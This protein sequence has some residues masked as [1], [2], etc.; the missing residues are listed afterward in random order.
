MAQKQFLIDGGFKTNGDSMLT[1][2]LDMTGHIIPSIDSDGTTGYDLGSPSMKW[3]DLYLSQGSLYIDG[4]KVIESNN[5]TIV[6]TADADQSVSLKTTGTG[7]TTIQ[8]ETTINMSGTLQMGAGKRITSADGDSVVF[9]DKINCDNNQIKN[10]TN[11]TEPQDAATKDYVDDKVDDILNGAPAALDTLNELSNALGDDANFAATITA[12][13]ASISSAAAVAEMDAV[14]A[15]N[16]AADATA[17]ATAA[18]VAATAA[19]AADASTK[20]NAAQVAAAADA[21]A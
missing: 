6:I 16:A 3:R 4:Q 14:V 10:V 21:S 19:A 17:K 7:T 20:A 15:A 1:G 18:Q 5:G 12:Q 8:S 9:G 13:L 11:P 2:N